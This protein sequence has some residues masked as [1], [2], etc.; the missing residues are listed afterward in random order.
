MREELGSVLISCII[1]ADGSPAEV[2]VSRG[3]VPRGGARQRAEGD[4]PRRR[5]SEE[6][7]RANGALPEEVRLSVAG[8]LP[9][10]ESCPPRPAG[11]PVSAV[12][13]HGWPAVVVH[14][15]VQPAAQACRPPV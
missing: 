10:D 5:G 14:P 8:L 4:L 9:D 1:W 2:G 15:V 11:R 6:V 13:V 3:R 7:S 12:A